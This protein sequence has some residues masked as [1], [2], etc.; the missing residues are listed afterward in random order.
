VSLRECFEKRLL[1]E[2]RKDLRKA[3]RS[4]EMAQ[5]KLERAR[6]AFKMKLFDLSIVSGYTSMFHASGALL[7]KDGVQEKS[8][9]CL[10]LYLRLKYAGRVPVYLVNSMD[11]FRI[12]RHEVLYGLE[13]TPTKEDAEVL[14]RDAKEF[15]EVVEG[16]LE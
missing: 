3:S 16:L 8:H 5:Q 4:L 13:F 6:L 9:Y 11:N 7:Y 10:V 12:A 14:L 1:R 15:L 2:T